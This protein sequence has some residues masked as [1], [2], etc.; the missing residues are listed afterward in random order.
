MEQSL[1]HADWLIT[2][3]VSAMNAEADQSEVQQQGQASEQPSEEHQAPAAG[4]P[5]F[6][7]IP[8]LA[9]KVIT[10]P[11]GFYQQ[12]PKSG[13]L[14][15]PLIF[16]VVLSV[17]AGVLSAVLSTMGLGLGGAMAGGLIAIIM[18]P[19]FVVIFGFVGAGIAYVIWNIMGSQENFE[20]AFRCV[21]Y[22]AAIAPITA[23]LKVVPYLGSFAS[24]LWPVAM[25]AIASIQV[26]RRS[27]QA[28][29]VVFGVIGAILALISISSEHTSRQLMSGMDD[30]QEIIERQRQ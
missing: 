16:M 18:V 28:S 14:L 12:M 9:I 15:D 1:L 10:N 24:A 3:E 19:I 22:T 5:N 27:K 6:Q 2:K 23:I 7:E 11:V 20:T 13:G 8:G 29:W 26:H 25:L 17:V 4:Q 21:A 30:W